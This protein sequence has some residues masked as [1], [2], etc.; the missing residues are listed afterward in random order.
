[1]RKR[2][3][4]G[5][6]ILHKTETRNPRTALHTESNALHPGFPLS[7]GY[8]RYSSRTNPRNSAR[9]DRCHRRPSQR[10]RDSP[11][12]QMDQAC[13]IPLLPRRAPRW[14]PDR[15]PLHRLSLRVER[16]RRAAIRESRLHA[17][18][19]GRK[20]QA[21]HRS[22]RRPRLLARRKVS[23]RS[24]RRL[25]QSRHLSHRRLVEGSRHS[26]RRSHRR[27]SIQKQL[28]RLPRS[29]SRRKNPLRPRSGQ[30]A[31]SSPQRHGRKWHKTRPDRRHLHRPLSL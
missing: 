17:H 20:Q 13:A 25:R 21:R 14:R 12:R 24:H 9:A 19:Q 23:L 11:C 15:N 4:E 28:R 16:R 18:A 26:A 29:L 22:L 2:L 1:M 7:S 27:Q 5:N 6:R 30:L 31:C 8:Y 10:T 3:R